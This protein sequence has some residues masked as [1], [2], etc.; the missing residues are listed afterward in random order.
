MPSLAS[1]GAIE[2]NNQCIA[3]PERVAIFMP[4]SK[5]GNTSIKR[6]I[7]GKYKTA[8]FIYKDEAVYSG[9]L[10]YAVVRNPFDRLVS[11]Y[12]YFKQHNDGYFN[13]WS[14]IDYT[15]FE[16]FIRKV[17]KEPDEISNKHFRSQFNLL[18][19]DG[20]FI[21]NIVIR[22]ENFEDIKKYLDLPNLP[23]VHKIQRNAYQQYYS[24]DM[25]SAVE[26][27]FRKDLDFFNYSFDP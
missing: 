7:L 20:L 21:P 5:N 22:Y 10:K 14:S 24:P 27:R 6:A 12:E 8:R 9:F 23:V 19:Q 13:K 2:L 18:S 1:D 16:D 4:V 26:R 3:I 15:D 11:C 25:V 17:C